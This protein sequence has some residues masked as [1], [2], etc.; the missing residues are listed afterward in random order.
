MAQADVADAS[1]TN[2]Q[3]E[4]DQEEE[5]LLSVL[6]LDADAE[7]AGEEWLADKGADDALLLLWSV[8]GTLELFAA[9]QERFELRLT[10]KALNGRPVGCASCFISF[11]TQLP[12][13]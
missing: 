9:R 10:W 11:H 5:D 6:L 1:L 3:N 7:A 12:V 2:V 4:H 8:F 13:G